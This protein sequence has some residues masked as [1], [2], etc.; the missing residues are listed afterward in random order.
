MQY[1]LGKAKFKSEGQAIFFFQLLIVNEF[2]QENLRDQTE[3]TS[4]PEKSYQVKNG[5]G[6]VVLSL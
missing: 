2:M 5:I 3:N 4:A 1:G 6:T